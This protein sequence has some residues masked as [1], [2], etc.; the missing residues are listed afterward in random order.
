VEWSGVTLSPDGTRVLYVGDQEVR[1][2]R[3]LYSVPVDGN[4]G[5]IR[6]N[7]P[8]SAFQGVS[9]HI[10]VDGR[11]VYYVAD[12]DA[13]DV[14]QLYRVPIDGSAPSLRLNGALVPGGD[15]WW[16]FSV[17]P[18]GSRVVYLADRVDN[19]LEVYSVPS[20]GSA[21]PIRLS[22]AIGDAMF[23]PWYSDIVLISPDS[24]R[25]VFRARPW[26]NEAAELYGVP[27]DGGA[28]PVRLHDAAFPDA[29]FTRDGRQLVH[30]GLVAGSGTAFFQTPIDRAGASRR[31]SGV[32]TTPHDFL[33]YFT[34]ELTPDGRVVYLLD[35]E[36]D[37]VDELF[38][39]F[40]GRVRGLAP[41]P[42]RPASVTR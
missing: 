31:I 17:A 20:D 13:D 5:P 14:H 38:I 6:L 32:G 3:Q 29:R 36:T 9:V 27:I 21:A 34:F 8:I 35:Q 39:G 28:A 41:V 2:Q 15:V 26:A 1:Y 42:P 4:T 30:L 37:S 19:Q 10:E 16:R 40:L 33:E 7:P 18:D 24:A 12:Q 11:F 23:E 22:T 25:V